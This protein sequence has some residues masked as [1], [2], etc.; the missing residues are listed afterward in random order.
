MDTTRQNY[1]KEEAKLVGNNLTL[2]EKEDIKYGI[3]AGYDHH[4]STLVLLKNKHGIH[5]RPSA[6]IVNL[7][8]RYV[9]CEI[10]AERKHEKINAKDIMSW[11]TLDAPFG[12]E[13]RLS[14]KGKD[15]FEALEKIVVLFNSKF[16]EE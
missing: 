12:A 1:S 10:W 8:S 9:D 13:V 16:N 14:A 5:A 11:M 4:C 7:V 6:M 3:I 15:C 2:S